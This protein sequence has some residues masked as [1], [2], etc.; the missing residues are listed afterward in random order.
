MILRVEEDRSK[1]EG[2]YKDFK[3]FWFCILVLF[4]SLEFYMFYGYLLLLRNLEGSEH[5]LGNVYCNSSNPNFY[6][7]KIIF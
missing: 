2:E 1:S 5:P 6:M 7:I 4:R 3:K